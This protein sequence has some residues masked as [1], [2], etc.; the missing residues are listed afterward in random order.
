MQIVR[1]DEKVAVEVG[2][3]GS[4]IRIGELTGDDARV[5]VQVIYLAAGGVISRHEAHAKQMLAVVAG[6]GW[7]TGGDDKRRELGTGRAAVWEP[8]ELHETGT[9]TGL[10]ALSVEGEFELWAIAVTKDI[11]VTD[12]DSGWPDCFDQ[13][14]AAV[15]PAVEDVALRIDHVGSTSVPGLAAKA[16]IDMDIVVASEDD[17]RPVIERLAKI[18]YRWRGELGVEGRQ[19]FSSSA[20]TTGAGLP[21]HHLYL[22]VENN[23]AHLDHWLLRDL[24]RADPAARERY[25]ELKRHNAATADGD[26]DYYVGAKAAFVAQLLTRA[27][28]DKGLPP[29][30]YWV[31]ETA[32]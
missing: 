28:L 32:G 4:A 22:V 8:G 5:R 23:K 30:D 21:S 14:A 3:G 18:G 16:V 24:L 11:V 15:W 9:E 12:Y 17:V 6:G 29:A 13:V 2:G 26:I 27:R 7:A 1:F 31:P 19:A 20:G 25:A 10:T